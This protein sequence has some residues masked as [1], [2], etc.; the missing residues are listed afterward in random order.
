VKVKNRRGAKDAEK[1]G[2]RSRAGHSPLPRSERGRG[3][4]IMAQSPGTEPKGP[5]LP[6]PL[7]PPREEREPAAAYCATFTLYSTVPLRPEP[8]VP[9][10]V[11]FTAP[12]APEAGALMVTAVKFVGSTPFVAL[13]NVVNAGVAS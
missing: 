7:L 13:R 10:K 2:I 5:P 8:R 6:S 9:V 3:V 4:L 1:R 12:L 11:H